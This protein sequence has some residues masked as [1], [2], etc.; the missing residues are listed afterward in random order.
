MKGI[1]AT[2]MGAG[3]HGGFGNTKGTKDVFRI[4]KKNSIE[5]H[6]LQKKLDYIY[7]GEKSFIPKHTVFENK[8][9]SIAGKGSTKPIRKEKELIKQYGGKVGDWSK[10]VAKIKSKKYI[11]DIHFYQKEGVQYLVKVKSRRGLN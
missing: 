3:V 2:S 7:N 4:G 8:P 11:F 9:K 10:K 5:E 6:Y 1:K